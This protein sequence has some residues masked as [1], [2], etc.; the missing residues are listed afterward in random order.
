MPASTETLFVH[1]YDE[2][3][4]GDGSEDTVTVYVTSDSDSDNEAVV[5]VG[6]GSLYVGSI[7]ISLNATR[8][9]TDEEEEELYNQYVNEVEQENP[10]WSDSRV[11]G[12]ARHFEIKNIIG[13]KDATADLDRVDQQ[14][15]KIGNDFIQLSG[16][17]GTALEF[18]LRGG[19]GRM[20]WCMTGW[21]PAP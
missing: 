14:K 18:N 10:D 2:G 19:S 15:K 4:I 5:C 17:D 13:V 1:V 7:P 16:E 11:E 6:T 3:D 8:V 20:T 12:Y 9:M 21:G